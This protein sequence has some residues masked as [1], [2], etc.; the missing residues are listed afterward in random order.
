MSE[1]RGRAFQ[2][3]EI[4]DPDSPYL[5]EL[6]R[7]LPD[8][9]PGIKPRFRELLAARLDEWGR[10]R[11]Q[12]FCGTCQDQVAGLMQIFYRPWRDALMGN[13]DLLGVR[14]RYRSTNLGLNLM[15]QAV[16]A[17]L[18]VSAQYKLPVAGIVWLTEP[19]E[20]PLDSWANRRVRM[21]EKLGG[22][23]RRELRYRYRGQRYP[24]GELIFWYPLAE[25][26]F[27]VD[28]KSLAWLLW[29][30]GELPAEEFARRYGGPE[31]DIEK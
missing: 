1:E 28:T 6:K 23:A 2:I 21:F 16:A 31:A 25:A 10:V 12:L 18:S 30:F 11:A 26:F 22:Q 9:L 5:P 15:R 19:D 8:L 14:E 13:V 24:D 3:V 17:T 4:T 29:Q 27:E 7:T 20:G